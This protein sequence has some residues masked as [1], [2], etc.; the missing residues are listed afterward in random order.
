LILLLR[1]FDDVFFTCLR[2][3]LNGNLK[4]HAAA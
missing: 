2:F 4:G 1:N 3:Y